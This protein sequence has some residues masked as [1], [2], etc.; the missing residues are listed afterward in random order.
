MRGTHVTPSTDACAASAIN[1]ASAF[2]KANKAYCVLAVG[3]VHSFQA[4]LPHIA[5]NFD[6]L[7]SLLHY[8][9]YFIIP[10]II[11]TSSSVVPAKYKQCLIV[12]SYH[13]MN[14][15][16]VSIED[17]CVVS[18]IVEEKVGQVVSSVFSLFVV[19]SI[20]SIVVV[21]RRSVVD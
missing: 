2:N 10:F 9:D 16:V 17:V 7:L 6:S 3:I 5:S 1:E 12:L 13:Q 14:L 4:H 21:S 8:F 19:V 15:L 11:L 20:I 18:S